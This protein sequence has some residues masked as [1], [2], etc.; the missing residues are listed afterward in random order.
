V[1]VGEGAQRQHGR[2]Q[3]AGDR[4]GDQ[5]GR[6][7][8][9]RGGWQVRS[10]SRSS[11]GAVTN[12]A[13]VALIAWVRARIA[14]ARATRSERIIST[15]PVPALGA[16]VAWPAC[17]ARAAASASSG[18]DLPRRRRAARSQR[19]TSKTTWPLAARKR[20]RAAP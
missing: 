6:G 7:R 14:V 18:S 9:Q 3:W 5:C 4:A 11:A 19:L 17:T 13:L 8:H 16:T 2:R 15:C 10:C 12:S 1:A 20:A